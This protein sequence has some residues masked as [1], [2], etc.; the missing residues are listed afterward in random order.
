MYLVALGA[1]GAAL[2][3]AIDAARHRFGSF[4]AF[5]RAEYDGTITWRAVGSL[6]HASAL[7]LIAVPAA[8]LVLALATG[9]LRACY[10]DALAN[11]R[12]AWRPPVETFRRLTLY[13]ILFGLIELAFIGLADNDL[14]AYAIVLLLATTPFTL[15]ADYAIVLDGVGIADGVRRSLQVVRRRLGASALAMALLVFYLP[16][17]VSAAFDSGFTDSTHVQPAYLVAWLLAG[18]LVQFLTDSVLITLYRRTPVSAAG[19]DGPPEASRPPGAS[20]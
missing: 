19:S 17:L 20:D 14:G 18:T 3:L 13:S 2:D 7:V 10:I 4:S 11:G 5:S 6:G 12:Y 1:I 8:F 15:Y 16:L 9:W